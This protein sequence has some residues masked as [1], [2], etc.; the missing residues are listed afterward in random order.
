MHNPVTVDT[1]ACIANLQNINGVTALLKGVDFKLTKTESK[2]AILDF[3]GSG[4]TF[5]AKMWNITE[6][7][8]KSLKQIQESKY[9]C[10]ITLTRKDYRNLPAFE[11]VITRIITEPYTDEYR[12]KRVM[13]MNVY[14]MENYIQ[15]IKDPEIRVICKCF[16]NKYR[17]K[18]EVHPAGK[19]VHHDFEGG[20]V[21][22]TI[23]VIS[24]G[25]SIMIGELSPYRENFTDKQVDRFICMALFHDAGKLREMDVQGNYTLEGKSL[26]HLYISSIILGSVLDELC[27]LL[28]KEDKIIIFN[29]ILSHHNKAEWGA[30]APSVS[31]EADILHLVDVQSM[32]LS[33]RIGYALNPIEMNEDGI[34]DDTS[35][36][37]SYFIDSEMKEFVKRRSHQ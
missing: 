23:E 16:W 18:L 24:A 4:C 37:R 3:C 29:G 1:L 6:D 27:I 10:E 5:S 22:H 17:D 15:M 21:E 9:A 20:W 11:A 8:E 31:V 14:K 36:G 35:A 32:H 26:G 13:D 19:R 28:N 25:L 12:I 2:F 7:V 33:K 30:V 34:V